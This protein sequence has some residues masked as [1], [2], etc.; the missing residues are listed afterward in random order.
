MKAPGVSLTMDSDGPR[1][2]VTRATRAE[3]AIWRAVQEAQW[4]YER[5]EQR[6]READDWKPR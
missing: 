3:D 6:K 1:L 2:S 4:D 5:N